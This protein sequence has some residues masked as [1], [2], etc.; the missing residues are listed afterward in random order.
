MTKR[1]KFLLPL[2]ESTTLLSVLPVQT[3]QAEY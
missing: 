1:S 3:A 2:L